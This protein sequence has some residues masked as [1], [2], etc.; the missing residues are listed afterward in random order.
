[1]E[2]SLA[3]NPDTLAAL[4]ARVDHEATLLLTL[5]PMRLP[6]PDEL[7][8]P[9]AMEYQ[10]LRAVM[11]TALWMS[12][13][14]PALL[15]RLLP[16]QD[17]LASPDRRAELHYLLCIWLLNQDRNDEAAD[18]IAALALIHHKSPSS[19][20]EACL[21][22]TQARLE[23]IRGE[24]EQAQL[25]ADRGL[26]CLEQAGVHRYVP[27]VCTTLYRLA[28]HD[29]RYADSRH[30]MQYAVAAARQ[31]GNPVT[32]CNAL[33][34]LVECLTRDD[35]LTA[36]QQA[37]DEAYGLLEQLAPLP[38]DAARIL[39]AEIMAADAFLKEKQAQAEEGMRLLGAS[40]R[41]YIDSVKRRHQAARRLQQLSDMQIRAGH[42]LPARESLREAYELKLQ[43]IQGIHSLSLEVKIERLQRQH[44]EAAAEQAR[45]HASVLERS[46]MALQESLA[47]QRE[48]Q[49]ELIEQSRLGSLG[50][51]LAGMA[52]EMNTPLGN[53]LTTLGAVVQLPKAL[54]EQMARGQLTRSL[55]T[56]TLETIIANGELALRNL[57]RMAAL[58]ADYSSLEL[59][60][61]AA[62]PQPVPLATAIV[63][64]WEEALGQR[65]D[66]HLRLEESLPLQVQK[67]A[68]D[69]ILVQ[70]FSNI[71][72]HAYP[73]GTGGSVHLS[74]GEKDGRGWLR[75]D[76][77][78]P[79][80]PEALLPHVFD[81]Y[82]SSTFGQGRNG[83]GLFQAQAVAWRQLKGRLMVR[84]LDGGGC[85]FELQWLLP[86]RHEAALNP[87]ADVNKG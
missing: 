72:R 2:L 66:I 75:V 14:A 1:M 16:Q 27:N 82:V 40:A 29:G 46:N 48:M 49:Q 86:P 64:A 80:I 63:P 15:Q 57:Q 68:F 36:A 74:S 39:A 12:D 22:L 61:P 20:N 43:E 79:G 17:L 37:V 59:P 51:M 85:R 3:L 10:L 6:E 87:D 31:A 45:T 55:L 76:D 9:A 32:T 41:V 58:M 13:D 38:G 71:A 19:F 7:Q 56:Q 42:L 23:F 21:C 77:Q 35:E 78:G 47:L 65:P 4:W 33:T 53:A 8:T 81:P 52:H 18:H 54:N 84:N 73:P 60:L 11:M 67:N 28:E 44:A 50:A 5:P 70:L 83:L 30:S 24:V 69:Q 34:G 26:A 62:A 25:H